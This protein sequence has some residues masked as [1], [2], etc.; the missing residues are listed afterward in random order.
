MFSVFAAFFMLFMKKFLILFLFSFTFFSVFSQQKIK[1]WQENP[2]FKQKWSELTVFLPEKLDNS[3]ISVIICPGGSYVYLDM[4]NEGFAVA[5]YLNSKGITAFVLK[6]RTAWQGNHHPAMIQD[7]QRAMQIVKE[8]AEIYKIDPEKIGVMGFSAGG[9]LAGTAAEYG[10]KD[11]ARHVFTTMKPYFA[12]MIYPVVSMEDSICHKKSRKNLL[13]KKYLP[14]SAKMMSL[15]QNI[16][17][18]MPPIFLLHCTGD[19]TV[20]YRNSVVFDKA[21]TEKGIKHKFLLFDE[22]GHGG[23]GFG[24]QPNGK[25]TGWIE[26]FVDWVVSI[27]Y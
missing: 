15:E 22:T 14:E 19:K 25:A 4:D 20:D 7:L 8:N 23:H 3:G 24:I 1:L 21:L 2:T 6:Y 16:P 12:A 26:A 9:H 11:A 27:Q 10:G 5:K 17:S 13:G 18:D